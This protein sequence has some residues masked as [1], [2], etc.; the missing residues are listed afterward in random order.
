MHEGTI[1]RLIAVFDTA[2]QQLGVQVDV[3]TLEGLAVLIHKAM[4]VQARNY[5]NLEHVLSL[6]Y[7]PDPI[8]TLAALFHDIVYYQVDLGFMPD[9]WDVIF[10]YIQMHD[11]TFHIVRDVAGEDRLLDLALDAFDF[12][13]GQELTGTGGL[14]EFLSVLVMNRKLGSFVSLHD[15]LKMDLCIE[16]TI[17]FRG[18]NQA[19]QG[20]F[21]VL[22]DR[23]NRVS[24]AWGIPMSEEEVKSAVRLA[25]KMAN[26]DVESF[27]EPEVGKFLENTWKL[28]PE[29]NIP[30]RS[31]EVYSIREYRQALQRMETFFSSLDPNRV[32]HH[33][34]GE[35]RDEV[36]RQMVERAHF[37]I[38]SGRE[39]LRVKLLAQAILEALAE[40][41]GGD[42][43]LS[44]FMGDLPQLGESVQR[45]EDYLP[46]IEKPEWLDGSSVVYSLLDSGRSGANPGFDLNTSPLTLHL[47]KS[48]PPEELDRVLILARRMFDGQ[49]SAGEFLDCCDHKLV[50]VVAKASAEMV[51]TRKNQL[52]RYA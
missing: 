44:L 26:K 29:M 36:F 22:E 37:N 42:A 11:M 47:Y 35:P 20:H 41:S 7:L 15:L 12:R 43:P 2:F 51:F 9:I 45:L 30:L 17:P 48:M 25:V 14:N 10:P 19:G 40:V 32:F 1:H 13:R 8:Q 18:A 31:R 28:L 52:L 50:K 23:L 24:A 3:K 49:L 5:H 38:A 34:D 39:Y 21:E 27:A 33:Y 6:V 4:T 16:A 46:K